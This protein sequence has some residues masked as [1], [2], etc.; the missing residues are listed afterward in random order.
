M[1]IT[2]EGSNKNVEL[3]L[4]INRL[5]MKRKGLSVI[6]DE[7]EAEPLKASEIIALIEKCETLEDLKQYKGSEFKTVI[8]ALDNRK[9]ELEELKNISETIE[10]IKKCEKIEH[11]DE[12]SKDER[13]A[14]IKAIEEKKAELE[15]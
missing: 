4:R 8:K 2:I 14:V 9:E 13:E 10:L 15:G 1:K 11:L 12:Y 5:F 7:P 6:T 3:L